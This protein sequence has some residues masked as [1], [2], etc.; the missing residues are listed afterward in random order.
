MVSW[1]GTLYFAAHTAMETVEL[2]KLGTGPVPNIRG[3]GR[4]W[5]DLDGNGLQTVGEPGIAGIRVDLELSDGSHYA[6]FTN[7]NG[8][9][10]FDLQI[11]AGT[12]LGMT[13]LITYAPPGYSF[14]TP[15]DGTNPSIDS[16]F[17]G[18][19]QD[20]SGSAFGTVLLGAPYE[21]GFT[22][23]CGFVLNTP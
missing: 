21:T 14:T 17:T 4:M 18:G 1:G 20:N 3:Q 12:V 23:D 10:G 7:S 19:G 5:D 22:L 9:Y 2:W 11:P 13:W 6:S 16:D 8:N 15:G